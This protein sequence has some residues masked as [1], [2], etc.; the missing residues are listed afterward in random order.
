MEPGFWTILAFAVL[1]VFFLAYSILDGFDLGIAMLVPFMKGKGRADGLM[2]LIT[3]FWDG[4]EVWL[5]MGAGFL[6]AAFPV[7]FGTLLPLFY[8]PFMAVI[9]AFIL[10]AVSIEFSYHAENSPAFWQGVAGAASAVAAFSG[11]AALGFLIQGLP[12]GVD[13]RPAQ[14][15]AG[16]GSPFPFLLGGAGLITVLWHGLAYVLAKSPA[17]DFS[18]LAK[19]IRPFALVAALIIACGLLHAL[20]ESRRN[21]LVTTAAVLFITATALSGV[22]IQK[23]GRAFLFSS[24]A[25]ANLWIAAGAALFPYA[26]PARSG[27]FPGLTL[28]EC[29]SPLSTL[30]PISIA[31][32]AV[33]PVILA[34]T[35]Y[36][37]VVFRAP[38]PSPDKRKESPR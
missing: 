6:F 5:V 36:V 8:L 26:L 19:K 28:A 15:F 14:P 21:P 12:F 23:P 38:S 13:G 37:Y 4:N 34:Y 35:R 27:I 11:L 30:R 2:K 25:V 7:A 22:R 33:I 17:G 10:R 18:L 24:L 29:A 3:P 1:L 32:V 9:L 31:A 20:P 16:Y